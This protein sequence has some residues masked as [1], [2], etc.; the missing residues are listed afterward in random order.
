[1]ET[2]RTSTIVD[3]SPSRL[4]GLMFRASRF[5]E[6]AILLLVIASLI[7]LLLPAYANGGRTLVGIWQTTVIPWTRNACFVASIAC[8]I[9][10][11]LVAR[12]DW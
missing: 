6:A 12:R 1:M 8:G 9:A 7:D 5:A 10:W 11:V 3:S 4:R 2:K